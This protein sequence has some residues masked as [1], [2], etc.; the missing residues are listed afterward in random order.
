LFKLQHRPALKRLVIGG[1]TPPL[2]TM[3][4]ITWWVF[5][6]VVHDH[7]KH[8][9]HGLASDTSPLPL[10]IM[11]LVLNDLRSLVIIRA[12]PS[13]HVCYLGRGDLAFQGAPF[14]EDQP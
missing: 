11:S 14:G 3:F 5:D 12:Q 7:T 8:P 13:I 2:A 9:N 1:S 4:S 10:R 6:E